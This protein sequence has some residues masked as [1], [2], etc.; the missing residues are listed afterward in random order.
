MFLSVIDL[1]EVKDQCDFQGNDALWMFKTQSY[2][3]TL[4][5]SPHI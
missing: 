5:G 2:Y 1:T 3:Y 4:T